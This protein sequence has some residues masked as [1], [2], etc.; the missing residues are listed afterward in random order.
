ML[1]TTAEITAFIGSFMWP[2]MRIGAM[3][4]AAP[5]YGTRLVPTRIK[6]V[7]AFSVTII[8]MPLLA[9]MPVV[10]PLS[11]DG[12]I[13]ALQQV[14]IGVATGFIF[15]MVFG[16]LIVAGESIAMA[17]GLGFA[18]MVDPSNGVTVPVVSQ[19]FLITGI[20]IFLA[21]GGHLT[22]IQI[23]IES[24]ITLPVSTSGLSRDGLWLLVNWGSSMFL[25]ALLIALPAVAS[26]LVVLLALGITTRAAPQLNIFSVGFALTLLIGFIIIMLIMPNLVPRF[27]QLMFDGF[28]LSKTMTGG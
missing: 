26:L 5:I 23:I 8:V 9:D 13:I 4:L 3:F 6:I 14:M 15:Q 18:S 12:L 27:T 19:F 2:F 11:I 20:L 7:L 16:A 22:L 1:I 28:T 24:F 25:G 21:L 10:E 17:M